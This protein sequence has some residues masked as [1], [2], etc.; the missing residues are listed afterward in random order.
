MNKPITRGHSKRYMV[1]AALI[2]LTA[3]N[4]IAS[5]AQDDNQLDK[6][7]LRRRTHQETQERQNR[8]QQ[9]D[10]FLQKDIKTT[11]DT[12]LPEERLSFAI[13]T[14]TLEGER[15]KHF[16]WLQEKLNSYQGRHIGIEGINLIVKR[17]TN[18]LIARGYITTRITIPEQDLS[19]GT[20]RLIL[21]PGIIKDIRFASTGR[22]GYWQNAFPAQ[23]GDILNLRDLEQGL[24]QLK[25]VPSQDADMQIEPGEKPGES[26]IVITLK[27]TKPWRFSTSIDNSGSR[28]TGKIQTSATLSLDNLTNQ[29]DLFYISL[30]NDAMN[31]GALRG[32]EGSSFYYSIPY[33]YWTFTLSNSNYDY[34]QTVSGTNQTFPY[35][36]NSQTTEFRAQRVLHRDQTSKTGAQFRIIKKDSRNYLSDTE[37]TN[38]RKDVTADELSLTHR[39]YY[40]KTVLDTELSYRWG[41]PWFGA[42]S[43][44]GAADSPTTRYHLW[45]LDTN[46][47]TPLKLG[48]K[49]G[50]YQIS[51]RAQQTDDILYTSDQF[52]IG[53]QYTVR[54][55]D[56]E[57]TLTAENGWYVR[58]ELSLPVQ[59][60]QELYLG[61][62]YGRVSGPS[63]RFLDG[64][65]L[66][67]AVLGV[68]GSTGRFSYDLYTGWPLHKPATFKTSS[69][70]LGF[71]LN[72]QY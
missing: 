36:G 26:N 8:Q 14:L 18:D 23:S 60:G 16:A 15:V 61:L 46:L 34:H 3:A 43:D 55:F 12:T 56:G 27:H 49:T 13:H 4:T 9:P 50:E 66:S 45:T 51:F 71:M 40:G 30:N 42:Q 11:E 1:V 24:E 29:N 19:H 69:H 47:S 54:G 38:Q 39:Q 57:Q 6:E 44:D 48:K 59:N 33:G 70:L 20:L 63:A 32:T 64:H 72:Y 5:Y 2:L 25:R 58:N 65:S 7:E 37:I 67:G 35:S 21:V 31:D 52:S 53:N 41:V 68:R 22:S 28:A 62:D 10:T 17:L